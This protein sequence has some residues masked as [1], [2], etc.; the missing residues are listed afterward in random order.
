MTEE[1]IAKKRYS[2]YEYSQARTK[3]FIGGFA[4]GFVF[5][6]AFVAIYIFA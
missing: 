6:L 1:Y 2:S 4:T 5:G 3:S